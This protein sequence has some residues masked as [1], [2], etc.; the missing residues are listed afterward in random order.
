MKTVGMRGINAIEEI[1]IT[2]YARGLFPDISVHMLRNGSARPG[3]D[4]LVISD[5][6]LCSWRPGLD[7]AYP[8]LVIAHDH[9]CQKLP[10]G[11]TSINIMGPGNDLER[12]MAQWLCGVCGARLQGHKDSPPQL[13]PRETEVI[14]LLR[15]GF[16]TEAIALK[17]GIRVPTVKMHLQRIYAKLGATNRNHAVAIFLALHEPPALTEPPES[18]QPPEPPEPPESRQ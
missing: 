1:G 12:G 11:V 13:G 5:R 8:V 4:G 3:L 9:N 18:P 2:R 17:L 16:A 15:K 14:H 10:V 6:V 7:P